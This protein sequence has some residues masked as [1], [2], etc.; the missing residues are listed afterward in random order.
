MANRDPG[1]HLNQAARL[2][3]DK[4]ASDWYLAL[5]L[6]VGAAVAATA[7]A[8][9]PLGDDLGL[10][11]AL[12]LTGLTVVA[13]GLRLRFDRR[14]DLA[15]TMRRQSV[16]TE[17][18][19]WPVGRVQRT[20]W[21]DA[22]GE[23]VRSRA[24]ARPRDADYYSTARPVGTARLAEMTVESAF[25]T[26]QLY[27]RMRRAIAWGLGAAVALVAVAGLAGLTRTVPDEADILIA[28]AI[29]AAVPVVLATNAFGWHDRL[30]RLIEAIQR[31]EEDLER[32][33]DASEDER[34]LVLRTVFEYNCQV[35][36]G[37]PIHRRLFERWCPEIRRLWKEREHDA[38]PAVAGR[39]PATD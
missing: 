33:R 10:L 39:L 32:R 6:E 24:G 20:R 22:A 16:L 36:G 13:Y 28:R 3:F 37:L 29:Y 1:E 18:L 30:G 15:E 8:L 23:K 31:V 9:L 34:A 27:R 14:Y 11:F 35:V 12:P 38:A 19:G 26:W 7:A 21:L 17:A 5:A 2:L 4:A 25:Y